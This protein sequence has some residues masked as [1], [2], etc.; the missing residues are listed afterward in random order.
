MSRTITFGDCSLTDDG[1]LTTPGGSRQLSRRLAVILRTLVDANE[2]AVNSDHLLDAFWGPGSGTPQYLTKA[3]F[4]LRQAIDGAPDMSIDS[5]YGY[6]YRLRMAHA[7]LDRPDARAR[8]IAICEEAAHRVYD[9]RDIA[10][11]AA[12]AM[13]EEA[14]RLDAHCVRAY[15]GYA[16][17]QLQLVGTGQEVPR[18]GW[19]AAQQALMDALHHD[20]QSADAHALRA[21]GQCLFEW[22]TEGALSFLD[23]A[24]GLAP[25]AYVPNEAA[26]RIFLSIGKPED[27]VSCFRRALEA[28]PMAMNTNGI[29]AM[30]LGCSGDTRAALRHIHEVCQLDPSNP[31]SRGYSAWVEAAYGDAGKACEVCAKV[32]EQ[33]PHAATIAAVYAFALASAGHA[34]EARALLGSLEDEGRY[35]TRCASFTSQA[36]RALGDHETAVRALASGARDRD[37]WLGIMLHHPENAALR[38]EPGFSAVYDAVFG[39]AGPV[40]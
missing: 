27:A 20:P 38:E 7:G 2:D 17:T 32:H 40:D 34:A 35:V 8:A 12:L 26:G 37:Y 10:L 5:I 18:A 36:W 23:T 25:T 22:D 14:S 1:M 29:L 30:A 28:N 13:Y 21:L 11:T 9:R 3:I 6:G 39:S 24:R 16:E 4:Q 15:T 19:R 33:L 31:I